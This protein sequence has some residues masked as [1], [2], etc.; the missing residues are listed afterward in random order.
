M[1]TC[2]NDAMFPDTGKAV[3]HAAAPARRR[4]R[5]PGGADLLRRSRW[6]TPATSTRRCRSCAPSSTASTGTTRSSRRPGR[7][8]G[9]RGTSTGSWP[10]AR[11]TRR[12]RRPSRETAPRVYELQRVPRRRARRDRRRRVLPAPGDLPPDLPLAADARRRRPAARGCCEAV[13]GLD[14]VDL[15]AAEECCGF[16]GTFAVKNADTSVAMGVGQGPP[17]ARD[18]RGGAGRRRQL[19]P[20]AHRRAALAAAGRRPRD[21]PGR[22]PG[23]DGGVGGGVDE[24]R[25]SSG[26]RRSPVAARAALADTQL[27]AQPRPRHRARSATSGRA[28]VAEVDDW[29]ELRLAGAAIKDDALR[30]S[31]STWS[32]L[33]A[34]LTA[35]G[36]DRALGPRR[37]RGLRDRRRGR[38]GATASTRSS[39]SS[40]W[41][42]RRSAST[43]R[44]P[45]EG[46]AAWETDLAE[47][48]VQLGDDLPSHILVPAI[49]R[50]RAEIR[51][52]FR[53]ADGGGRAARARRT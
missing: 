15:P 26:C 8:P 28:V 25:R 42:P 5:V 37:R 27:R 24:R 51:E 17:R 53:D 21:A 4:R 9:R 1:V 38:Q 48:I 31:T 41:P 32:R 49:H 18:R 45:R 19:L 35:R 2:V 12:W 50:N 36:R 10:G 20:D 11:A 7:A 52:I 14:L 30:T 39:R 23:R 43:R 34:S 29:E 22:D 6:S 40:R 16:G 44:S 13:R 33:E 46:I 3:V 47:L